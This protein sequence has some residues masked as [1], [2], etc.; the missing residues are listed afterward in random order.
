[1][2]LDDS[3]GRD[4]IPADKDINDMSDGSPARARHDA[5][6]RIRRYADSPEC[7]VVVTMRGRELVL[8]CPDYERA[9]RWAHLECKSY[10]ISPIFADG[11]ATA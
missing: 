2:S 9:V 3:P 10:G 1:M 8:A 5:T 6:V 4:T 11:G 7:D